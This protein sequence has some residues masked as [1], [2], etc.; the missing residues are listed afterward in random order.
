MTSL[1]NHVHKY[2]DSPVFTEKTVPSKLTSV[3]DTKAGVWGRLILIKGQLDYIILGPPQI[4][5]PLTSGTV[6]IIEPQIPHYV[7]LQGPV[8]FKIEFLK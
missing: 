2:A 4:V 5:K 7:S 6:A 3:H 1:P 8:E